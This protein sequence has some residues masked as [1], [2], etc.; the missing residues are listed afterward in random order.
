MKAY[1]Q[2]LFFFLL[3]PFLGICQM[4]SISQKTQNMTL[5]PGYFN[6]YVDNASGKLYLEIN[7]LDSE[8][9]YQTSLPSG[10]GSND[11]GL[12]RGIVGETF[13]VKFSHVGNKVLM[14]APNY[15]YRGLTNNAAERKAVEQSFARSVLWGF[16]VEAETGNAILVDATGFMLRDVMNVTNT[17]RNAQ[18]GSYTLDATRSAVYFPSTKNFP[19]NTELESTITFVNTD[20][21]PGGYVSS[22]SPSGSAVT[23]RVHQSFVQ[24]PDNNYKPRLYDARS[25]YNSMSFQDYSSSVSE[26]IVKYYIERHRL[27]KK[28]PT[29]LRSEAVNPIVYYLDNGTPEPIRSALLEGAKWW[30]QAFDAAGFINAFQVKIL[31]DSADPMDLRYNMVNWVHRATRGWSFGYSVVDP[32]TGEIIKGNVTLGSLRVRQDYL[33]AQGLLSPFAS[34]QLT[35]DKML[36]MSLQRL[37]QLAAHEIGHTLG[38]MHNYIASSQNTASVMDYPSPVV[39]LTNNEIDLNSTYTNEIG[40]WDKVAITYGYKQFSIGEDEKEGLNKILKD[41]AANGL[42]FI[43]DRDARDPAGMHPNAHLWDQG[44]DAITGLRDVMQV[45]NKALQN[46][47]I[48]TIKNGTPMA[49]LED[50]LV[51][52]YLYHR[53]QVEA[54][55]KVVGGTY[56]NYAVKGDGQLVTKPV[57]KE[58]QIN[59]LN[60]ILNCFSPKNLEIPDNIVKLIPPRPAQ[61]DYNRELFHRRTGLIFD[62]LAAAETAA[63]I[64]LSFLFNVSRLNRMAENANDHEGL[65]IEEMVAKIQKA[66][67]LPVNSKVQEQIRMQNEQLLLTYLLASSVNNETSFAAKASLLNILN[68]LKNKTERSLQQKPP[69]AGYLLL[70]LER[71][72]HPELAKPSLHIVAPPGS[73]IGDESEY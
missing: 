50:L 63:D 58:E 25:P 27:E 29:A 71:I 20:G 33:I 52:V 51:P 72:K 1:L 38:L 24:L 26:P 34:D 28:D 43:S 17:F 62:R 35:E 49:M 39:K 19:L 11:V 14:I 66:N 21:K 13:I 23:V 37:K 18:Q 64:P 56:Y 9:L 30:N 70:T 68:D 54:A 65:T 47:G 42:T 2:F 45:R 57:S 48:N 6:Y 5:H 31:P 10:L 16:T 61:Y 8:I 44:K 15:H 67:S 36:K 73:P 12:D 46:F 55:T 3:V 53:Y 60:E 41:A 4:P 32:R 7:K 40:S 69:S 22:V 59:A